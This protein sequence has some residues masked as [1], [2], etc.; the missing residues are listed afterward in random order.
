MT[1]VVNHF[2][3]ETDLRINSW[4][5][6]LFVSVP[7]LFCAVFVAACGID[8]NTKSTRINGP[9]MGTQ[10]NMTLL[11]TP[12]KPAKQWQAELLPIMESV[13][14]SMSTYIADSELMQFNRSKS[15]EFQDASGELLYVFSVSQ[16]VSNETNGA[17][18]VTVQPL[19]DLWGFGSNKTPLTEQPKVPTQESLTAIKEFVGYKKLEFS[20]SFTQWRKTHPN[21]SVDFSA[22]AK[23]YAVDQVSNHLTES[24]C[25]NYLVDIGGEVRV[26]G[27][28]VKGN[29]WRLA[30]EKPE[31]NNSFQALIDV[32]NVAV[33]SSGD[34]RNFYVIDG[35]RYSHTIDPRTLKPVTHNLAAVTVIDP[36]AA[37]ADALATA[38]MVMGEDAL[39][40]TEENKI[41]ALF[42]FRTSLNS[43]NEEPQ[44][45]V[46]YSEA[47]EQYIVKQQ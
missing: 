19:V 4:L 16:Q 11:C 9:I 41:P 6:R 45:Q 22:V 27:L 24:G 36:V 15:T 18:D 26:S 31:S 34:Y 17:F 33:A 44:Y 13:N 43:S 3:Q 14:Q 32:S 2:H 12:D 1:L 8:S 28:N 21:I 46:L 20:K 42:I 38:F 37:K 39:D 35:K 5:R 47:F 29:A 10:Y 30:I 25:T 23:G 40:F 7:T